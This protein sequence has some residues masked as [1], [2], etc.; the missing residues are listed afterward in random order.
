MLVIEIYRAVFHRS[1]RDM[2][3]SWTDRRVQHHLVQSWPMATYS[4][5][6]QKSEIK[7]LTHLNIKF[8]LR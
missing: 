4:S 5:N 3:W 6:V 7:G 2:A 8:E 1:R